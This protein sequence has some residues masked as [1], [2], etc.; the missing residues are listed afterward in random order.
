MRAGAASVDITPKLG[1]HLAGSGAGEHR[2][3]REVLDPLYARALVLEESG[4][5]LCIVAL[6]VTIVTQEWTD[7]IRQAAEKCG[8]APGSVLV[9]ATQTHSS[10][11]LGH[12][13]FDPDFPHLPE[14]IEYLRGGE[15]P[16]YEFATA[17][18]IEAIERAQA[19]LVPVQVGL[20]RAVRDDLAFNRRGV[21]RDGRVCMP[22]FFAGSQQPLGPVRLSHIEGPTDPEVGVAAFRADDGRIV[23]LLLHHTCH[24]VSVFATRYY[25]VS[26][27]WPGAWAAAMQKR[28]GESCVPIVLNGC[29]GNINPWPAFQPD[30]K[31]DHLRM[32]AALAASTA[33]VL[34]RMSFAAVNRLEWRMERIP[35]PLKPADPVRLDA[36]RRTLS[37]HPEPLWSKNDAGRIDPAW[38]QAASVMSVE[39]MRRRGPNLLYEVQVFRIGDMAV[40]GLPGEPFVEG[41]LAIKLG[42]RL[43]FTFVAHACTQYVGYIPM[44]EAFPRGGHEVDFSYWAKL[45]PEALDTIV[46]TSTRLLAGTG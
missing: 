22:W 20:G 32:G 27:D 25:A 6:D 26:A 11:P 37:E 44:R 39:L 4:R 28:G 7:R 1:T 9:H 13:M 35:I 29:C 21:Q 19:R 8:F 23:A 18:A 16:Y 43:P 5:R 45:V 31:P 2:P 34:D 12:I 17:R 41:Q 3:A 30:F 46:S 42:A 15:T 10:P 24:P 36:A 40:V 38:F 33:A 14:S